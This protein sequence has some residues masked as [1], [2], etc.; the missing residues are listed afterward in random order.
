MSLEHWKLGQFQ[1][2]IQLQIDKIFSLISGWQCCPGV[3]LARRWFMTTD[4]NSKSSRFV[5][6]PP[7]N[8]WHWGESKL[9]QTPQMPARR[10]GR[11]TVASFRTCQ[12]Q[13]VY[14]FKGKPKSFYRRSLTRLFGVFCDE[15]N[16]SWARF[17][18]NRFWEHKQNKQNKQNSYLDS[19]N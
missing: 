9:L 7:P 11:L 12:K 4:P 6:A 2:R 16:V 15:S 17:C 5:F 13:T 1:L 8:T 19:N 14:R 3:S 10:R 18:D